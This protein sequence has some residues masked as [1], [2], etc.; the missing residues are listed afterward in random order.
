MLSSLRARGAALVL[1][2]A[3]APGAALAQFAL[4]PL[5]YAANAL[6]PHIDT[7]TM[8]I[9]HGRHHQAFITALNAQA[10]DN[11]ALKPDAVES[12]LREISKH[13][14]PTRNAL[15]GHYNHTLFWTVMA[16]ANATGAP[17]ACL[18]AISLPRKVATYAATDAS[19]SGLS[20]PFQVNMPLSGTPS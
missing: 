15:G 4:P 6:E 5:P 13:P 10:K 12:V 16:P 9:H 11:P 18:P 17:S 7:M 8:E 20:T 1:A 3:A 2:L 14:V 19:S